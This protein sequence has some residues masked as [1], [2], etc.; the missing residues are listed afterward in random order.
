MAKKRINLELNPAQVEE[1][2]ILMEVSGCS[3]MKEFF[4]NLMTFY[5]WALLKRRDGREIGSF[6][7]GGFKELEMPI[8]GGL[9]VSELKQKDEDIEG[10]EKREAVAVM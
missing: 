1:L 7:N 4:N 9:S 8:F 2:K 5:K 6:K 10:V 3:T